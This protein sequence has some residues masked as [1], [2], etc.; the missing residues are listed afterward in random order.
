LTDILTSSYTAW[1]PQFGT[2]VVT[3]LMLP[4][5]IPEAKEWPRCSLISPKWSYFTRKA[6]RTEATA[7]QFRQCYL[8]Q[9]DR[10]GPAK[11]SRE[12]AAIAAEHQAERLVLLCFETAPAACHRLLFASWLLTT[13]GE[14][15]EEI[16]Q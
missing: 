5:W 1:R 16:T 7:E 4:R 6:D 13:T 11:I 2:P 14:V 8:A 3:S 15:I 10:H 12:L 9:L